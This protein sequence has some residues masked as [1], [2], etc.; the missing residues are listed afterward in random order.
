MLT[1]LPPTPFLQC[2]SSDF[3]S[4]GAN[5][6]TSVEWQSA[7][8][9]PFPILGF[10]TS[11]CCYWFFVQD[12]QYPICK[13]LQQCH[14]FSISSNL[15]SLQAFHSQ[16]DGCLL[17]LSFLCLPPEGFCFGHFRYTGALSYQIVFYWNSPVNYTLLGNLKP[18]FMDCPCIWD[19]P[20]CI[21]VLLLV[22]LH[23]SFCTVVRSL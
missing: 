20:A 22:L 21:Q 15:T 2:S 3:Y 18:F 23:M 19:T 6:W 5:V 11:P 16:M 14:H 7:H 10:C 1:V 13:L 17:L 9:S 4:T 12:Q 8:L